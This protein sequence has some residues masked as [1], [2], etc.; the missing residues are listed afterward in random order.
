VSVE[1]DDLRHDPDMGYLTRYFLLEAAV[2]PIG[3]EILKHPVRG[4]SDYDPR[5]T[6]DTIEVA[7]QNLERLRAEG[8]VNIDARVSI[9]PVLYKPLVLELAGASA[10]AFTFT[11]AN[12]EDPGFTGH[13]TS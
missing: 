13:P 2:E 9:P 12:D 6:P 7:W 4:L 10:V 8:L 1:V 5:G 3:V 11:D